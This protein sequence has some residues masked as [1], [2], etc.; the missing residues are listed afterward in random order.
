[1]ASLPSSQGNAA[2]KFGQVGEGEGAGNKLCPGGQIGQ[3]EEGSPEEKHRGDKE[4]GR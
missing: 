3:R 4:E 2:T 1:M